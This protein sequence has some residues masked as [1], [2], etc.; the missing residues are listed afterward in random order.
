[1]STNISMLIKTL[2]GAADNVTRS[3]QSPFY[4]S[5][6]VEILEHHHVD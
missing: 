2:T 1:M 5:K 6:I 3:E 4:A